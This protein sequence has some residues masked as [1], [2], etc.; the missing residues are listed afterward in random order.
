M[1]VL[2]AVGVLQ[3]VAERTVQTDVREPDDRDG[4]EC[5]RVGSDADDEERCRADQV[6]K[7]SYATAP[8]LV[9]AR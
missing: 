7:T 2:E 3:A 8:I 4:G 1:R 9:S 6:W 5:R